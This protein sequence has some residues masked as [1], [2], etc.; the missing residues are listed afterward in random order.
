MKWRVLTM[1]AAWLFLHETAAGR[2]GVGPAERKRLLAEVFYGSHGQRNRAVQRLYHLQDPAA[3][4]V[5]LKQAAA[6]RQRA[7]LS[8]MWALVILR[9]AGTQ[10]VLRAALTHKNWHVRAEAARGL[11]V[12]RS[13]AALRGLVRLTRDRRPGVRFAAIAALARL[14]NPALPVLSRLALQKGDDALRAVAAIGATSGGRAARALWALQIHKQV[15]EQVRLLAAEQLVRRL[16]PRGPLALTRLLGAKTAAVRLEAA[17]LLGRDDA[18][19]MGRRALE[20][21]LKGKDL[22]LRQAAA[23]ALAERQARG[24]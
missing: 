17:R 12:L 15:R 13:K 18:S 7:R 24:H 22:A 2:P 10:K 23:D 3:N 8:A 16:D 21:A 9:P 11:G 4:R 19:E 14:G 1:L 20:K 6:G 5:L